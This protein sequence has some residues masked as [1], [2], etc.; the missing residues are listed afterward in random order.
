MYP[1]KLPCRDIPGA[2]NPRLLFDPDYMED[3][4]ESIR[5]QGLLQP[6]LV[7][8]FNGGYQRVAGERRYHAFVKVFGLDAVIDVKCKEM[9]DEEARAAA[10]SENNQR[11]PMT[12][13]EVALSAQRVLE[14]CHGS[15][16]EAALHLGIKVPQLKCRLALMHA[17][18]EVREA[19]QSK[20][21]ELAHAEL[22][23]ACRDETQNTALEQMLSQPKV[24]R[25]G[26]LKAFLEH[27][28]LYL[29]R[30]LFDKEDCAGC[31]H[32]SENQAVLFGEAISSGRCTNKQCYTAKME[33]VLDAR[34]VEAQAQ[35]RVVKI[36]RPDDKT[37]FIPLCE[38]G[39]NG[40][41]SSQAAACKSCDSFGA[42]V[43]A[44]ADRYGTVA[45]DVCM[46]AKCHREKVRAAAKERAPQSPSFGGGKPAANGQEKPTANEKVAKYRE[47]LWRKIFTR[48]VTRLPVAENRSVLLAICLTNPGAIDKLSLAKSV[49]GVLP[50][51]NAAVTAVQLVERL[52][53]MAP[54]DL[55]AAIANIAAQVHE[56][57]S[58]L[59]IADV[60]SLLRYFKVSVGDYWKLS[61]QFLSVLSVDDID[62]MVEEL[63]IKQAMGDSYAA[64]RRS[65]KEA[66]IDAVL[67]VEGFEYRGKIP[68]ILM[69]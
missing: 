27:N 46:D 4:E 42:A 22:L 54:A 61:K 68:A 26:E 49:P 43:C 31:H 21:I 14:D 40:V 51:P 24:M 55:S 53:S 7:R 3:L 48:V 69:L 18:Q 52:L 38:D 47:E 63:G 25:P 19:L 23:A 67:G 60:G 32:N 65:A 44:T 12:P 15:Y 6:I 50:D 1:N 36:I 39:P 13:V 17:T 16:A 28:A 62:R 59:T 20:K 37:S 33:A 57:A 29:D 30:A 9:T 66:F 45:K 35:Y 5:A 41:G 2:Y 34:F 8:P 11:Q 56:G 58:P 10:D 64:A